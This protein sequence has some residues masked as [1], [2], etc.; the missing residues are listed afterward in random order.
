[1]ICSLCLEDIIEGQKTVIVDG[2]TRHETCSEE[3]EKMVDELEKIYEDT[4][5][6]DDI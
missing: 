1:M 4:C 6:Q 3:F 2:L 5:P